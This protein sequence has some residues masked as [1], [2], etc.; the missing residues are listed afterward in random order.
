MAYTVQFSNKNIVVQPGAIDNSTSLQFV[1]R[2]VTN[3]GNIIAQDLALL[4]ENF[5]G[6]SSPDVLKSVPGQ[7][8]FDTHSQSLNVFDG[9]KYRKLGF[10]VATDTVA[11]T[12]GETLT[13]NANPPQTHKVLSSFINDVRYS[14]LSKDP[15][16]TPDPALTGFTIIQPGLN[17]ADNTLLPNGGVT[18][19]VAD[20]DL[21][22]GLSSTSFMRTDADTGTTG[23]LI[24]GGNNGIYMGSLGQVQMNYD[25]QDFVIRNWQP[26]GAVRF[27]THTSLNQLNNPLNL[28]ADGTIEFYGNITSTLGNF[29]ILNTKD[30]SAN[31]ITTNYLSVANTSILGSNSNVK[32]T[33]GIQNQVLTTDGSGNLSW[34]DKASV[35]AFPIGDLGVAT[36]DFN[37]LG[38]E[39]NS[40]YAYDCAIQP[41]HG[42]TII[43]LGILG[44]S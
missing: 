1:G 15:P 29:Q 24:V 37:S 6:P 39:I 32:I 40:V 17:I 34:S 14:I 35:D 20:S 8:W 28:L 36:P 18:S 13:D 22:N 7:L 12:R 23:Q 3:Y 5:A 26:N 27:Y 25:G 19:K 2:Y 42:I 43:D 38:L 33:G 30:L 44:L 21:L 41:R 10:D 4:L 11:Y 9:T 16:F 31:R